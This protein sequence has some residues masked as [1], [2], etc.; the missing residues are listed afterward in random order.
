MGCKTQGR[1]PHHTTCVPRCP[2]PP[3]LSLS[4]MLELNK[5][6]AVHRCTH[7][8]T[9]CGCGCEQHRRCKSR[10]VARAAR[11]QCKPVLHLQ[12]LPWCELCGHAC[13]CCTAPAALPLQL[14]WTTDRVSAMRGRG[15]EKPPICDHSNCST[16]GPP[17]TFAKWLCDRSHLMRNLRCTVYLMFPAC[18]W[19]LA[20]TANGFKGGSSKSR[21]KLPCGGRW[22]FTVLP[23]ILPECTQLMTTIRARTV[24]RSRPLP[25][26]ALC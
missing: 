15:K 18:I 12:L 21:R 13:N 1:S 3:S 20:S 26:L 10:H 6:M 25:F 8:Y 14:G 24:G 19:M 17:P 16:L 11:S 23:P 22:T 5:P 9:C 2:S 4:V 7:R